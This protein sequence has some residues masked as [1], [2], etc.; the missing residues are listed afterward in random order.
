MVQLSPITPIKWLWFAYSSPVLTVDW[1]FRS[2]CHYNCSVTPKQKK[3]IGW[4]SLW[5]STN[6]KVGGKQFPKYP[7]TRHW[8]PRQ[9]ERARETTCDWKVI[10]QVTCF[11]VRLNNFILVGLTALLSTCCNQSEWVQLVCE[12]TLCSKGLNSTQLV[13]F[14]LHKCKVAK[15]LCNFAVQL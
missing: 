5:S 13:V 9:S 8:A 11:E 3:K 1:L 10:A 15:Y 6:W 4:L 7:W 2:S 12:V 14:C